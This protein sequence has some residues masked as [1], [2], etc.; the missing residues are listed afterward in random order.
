M[1]STRFS[2]DISHF[3]MAKNLNLLKMINYANI[4]PNSRNLKE[5]E[6]LLSSD[7][8]ITFGATKKNGNELHIL[9]SYVLKDECHE[10][11]TSYNKRDS[12]EK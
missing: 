4:T 5:A 1:F 3:I 10:R 11:D 12:Y 7:F 8:V 9:L 2:K 6:R